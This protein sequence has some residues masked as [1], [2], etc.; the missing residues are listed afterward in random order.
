[1]FDQQFLDAIFPPSRT[2]DFFEAL[3]GGAEEGAYT[4]S[5]NFHEADDKKLIFSFDLN[6]R[7]N[8]CLKC[9]L[10]TGLPQVFQ[11]HPII[12]AKNIAEEVAKIAGFV[13]YNWY[14]GSTVQVSE[15]LHYIP[16]I[17]EAK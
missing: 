12:N 10:T 6:Q 8:H 16:F 14:L 3:F 2:D 15:Q 11:R 5:L 17:I 4:I 13:E 9:N 1:M 7:G